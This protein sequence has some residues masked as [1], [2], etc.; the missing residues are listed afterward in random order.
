MTTAMTTSIRPLGQPGDLGWIIAA[1][2]E[3]YATEY[4]WDTG[5]EAMV[6]RIVADYAADHDP[7]REAAWIAELDGTRVGCVLC[8][9]DRDDDTGR[10]ARLRVML[11]DPAAR[12]HGLGTRLV[13]TV[14]DFA[15]AVGYRRV[16][17]WTTDR[18]DAAG[19]IYVKAGFRLVASTP[20]PAFGDE[21]NDQT[22][23][24]DLD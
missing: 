3:L 16:V 18:Q 2:G 8:V 15:R 9:R 11:V 6:A 7:V 12:G 23:E 20:Y 13:Q 21:M 14:L 5:F 10:T 24:L 1:H 4:G 22:Y 19:R 17:L